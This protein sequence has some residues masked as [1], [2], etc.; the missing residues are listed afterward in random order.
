M[1]STRLDAAL[2]DRLWQHNVNLA[3]PSRV[4]CRL[5]A[6]QLHECGTNEKLY[7]VRDISL[8]AN[9]VEMAHRE[10]RLCRCMA[11]GG[12]NIEERQAV[13]PLNAALRSATISDVSQILG[14]PEGSE[15]SVTIDAGTSKKTIT[16][17]FL[18]ILS[19]RRLE[20]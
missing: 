10:P 4:K 11:I 9:A 2:D 1:P 3:Q 17:R 13:G 7:S 8:D 14:R 19:P 16:I 5:R 15:A 12:R 20:V 18:D 6:S